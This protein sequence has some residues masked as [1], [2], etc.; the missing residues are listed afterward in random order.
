MPVWPKRLFVFGINLLSAAAELNLLQRGGGAALQARAFKHLVRRLASTKHWRAAGVRNGMRYEA[1][2]TLVPPCTYAQLATPIARTA[3]GETDVLWP[4]KCAL[5]ALTPGNTSAQRKYLPVTEE[6]LAH[7]RRA[8]LE[9]LLYFTARV[10]HA[11]CSRAA[12]SPT[13]ASTPSGPSP[14]P[15][16]PRPTPATS[17][18]SLRSTCRRGPSVTFSSPA[19][20]SR[21]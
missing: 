4:G 12:T 5:F 6:M 3:R 20:P 13:A 16:T 11:G 7:F 15:N 2:R 8:E 9:S 19:P 14:A 10:R 18:R 1:F 17:A 21:R